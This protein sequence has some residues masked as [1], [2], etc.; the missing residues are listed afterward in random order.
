MSEKSTGGTSSDE[1]VERHTLEE[2]AEGGDRTDWT[3][4]DA[5]SDQEIEAAIAADPDAAPVLEEPFWDA[6]ELLLPDEGGKER[7]T[8]YVDQ[9]VLDYFR[10]AGRGYQTRMNAVL[11]AYVRARKRS[12]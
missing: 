9:G 6:A 5:L 1:K 3:R 2:L 8:M 7:I 12:G 11:R 4:V 10:A